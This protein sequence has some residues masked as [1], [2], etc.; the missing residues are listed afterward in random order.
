MAAKE[1]KLIAFPV[2]PGLT[3]L[4]L[5]GPL[6]VLRNMGRTPYRTVVV[7]ERVEE[8]VTDTRLRTSCAASGQRSTGPIGSRWRSWA[9]STPRSAGSR[10]SGS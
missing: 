3:P 10:T 7:G 1:K 2:Y 5:I 4:D 6:T 8:L 9:P